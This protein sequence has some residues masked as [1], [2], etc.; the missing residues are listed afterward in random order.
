MAS[1]PAGVRSRF[2]FSKR[3]P[4]DVDL[5]ADDRLDVVGAGLLV[6]LDGAEEVAVVGLRDGRHVQAFARSKSGLC[7]MAPSR[8]E[9][10]VWRCRWTK[11]F[12]TGYSHSIVA[13][14]LRRDVVDH[15]V[16]ALHLVDDA[17]RDAAQHL[18]GDVSEVGRHG[19]H[20]GH[21]AH[22]RRSRRSGRRPSRPRSAPAGT[23]EGLPDL[24]VEPGG[25]I[26][27]PRWRSRRLGAAASSRS[28]R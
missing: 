25:A 2:S 20:R 28:A 4:R 27:S 17:A 9:Y 6:E 8:S 5:A 19:V 23:R 14:R 7:L 18:V 1:K 26:G 13:G 12:G 24:V 16:D 3:E 10:W 21:A 15:A 22:A 11:G